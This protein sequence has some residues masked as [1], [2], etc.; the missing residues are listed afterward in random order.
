MHAR[1]CAATETQGRGR[2]GTC[3]LGGEGIATRHQD[4]VDQRVRAVVLV[5]V[6]EDR[7]LCLQP[8][9]PRARVENVSTY[10]RRSA[11]AAPARAARAHSGRMQDAFGSPRAPR[12]TWA[13]TQ[14]PQRQLELPRAR[15]FSGPPKTSYTNW[16]LRPLPSACA[17]CGA[18]RGSGT[19][20]PSAS[21]S[22]GA[23]R[24]RPRPRP[25]R[26]R[27]AGSR[28]AQPPAAPRRGSRRMLPSR[29]SGLS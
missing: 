16:G 12:A 11:G 14:Q 13:R 17:Q 3:E 21:Q 9:T 5:D 4:S 1:A 18:A 8:Q 15:M 22:A 25:R 7:L 23:R 27:T 2:E 26:Q 10:L 20:T 24:Q 29:L 6:G 28:P 19:G